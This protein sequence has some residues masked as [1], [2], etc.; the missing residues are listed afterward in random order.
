MNITHRLFTYPVLSDE[1]N[2]YKESIFSVDYEQTMQ[3]VNSLKLTFDIAMNCRELEK[4]VLNGQAEYVI[5]LECSTTAYREVLRSVS[6]HIEHV[7]PIGRIN[8]SFDAVAFVVLKKN[9]ANFSC[10]DWV[11]D[12]SETDFNL[13]AGSILA[14]QNL[15]KLDITKD[16]EEFTNAGSIFSIY[17]RITED[18][19]PAEI[20]LDSA[21]IRI[22]LGSNDYE[23]YATY[24][25]KTE[26]QALLHTMIILPA[27]VGDTT[28][29]NISNILK[30][31]IGWNMNTTYTLI[32][33]CI[34]KG[35]IERSEPNFMCHALIPK[36]AVQEVET[37]E[38]IN[39]IYDGS[40]DKLFAALLSR[41]NLSAEQIEK[42]K[43]IVGD[44]E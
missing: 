19:C 11:D 28:A 25:A 33:R 37:N 16:Y 1:K 31:E 10:A 8:G 6:R 40:A 13:F 3:G 44:L 27:L 15:P 30:E 24:S 4:L 14:Y 29:K 41:K 5:H 17:K 18:D 2:D 42:L 7:I 22:G 32:K 38:L 21:K 39:K 35:A 36:E 12:Y 43:R 26:L 20:N 34:K 23:V 9:V